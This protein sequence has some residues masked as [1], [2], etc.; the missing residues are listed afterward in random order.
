MHAEHVWAK[1]SHCSQQIYW[2]DPG[3]GRPVYNQK[4]NVLAGSGLLKWYAEMANLHHIKFPDITVPLK[5]MFG[6]DG[7]PEILRTGNGPQFSADDMPNFADTYS[8]KH[9]IS[10]AQYPQTNGEAKQAVQKD[11]ISTSAYL[12]VPLT[13]VF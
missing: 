8:F 10:S 1:M 9:V 5:S 3:E 7:V 2:R 13:N 11:Q 12:V 4:E 6:C